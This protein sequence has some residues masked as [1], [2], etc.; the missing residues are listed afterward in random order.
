[1]S[2]KKALELDAKNDFSDDAKKFMRTCVENY[3]SK[4]YSMYYVKKYDEAVMYSEK[5]FELSQKY[6]GKTD[7]FSLNT[8]AYCAAKAKQFDKSITLY[9][10]LI[11]LNYKAIVGYAAIIELN[12]QKAD[13]PGL[14]AAITK[15]RTTFPNEYSFILEELNLAIREGKVDEAIKNLNLAIEKDPKNA[16]LHLVLGQTYQKMAFGDTKPANFDELLKRSESEFKLATDIKVD[17]FTGFYNFGVFY[18]NWG[19]NILNGSQKLTKMVEIQAEEKKANDLFLKA[20]PLLEKA[21][22]INKTDKDTMRALK[23]LYAKTGQAD[24]DKYRKLNDLLKN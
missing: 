16:E 18:S 8:A 13:D 15:A 6:L 24:T 17:Y 3:A 11:A 2:Y 14:K 9:E 5:A 23:Q 22:E 21:M 12:K 4:A 10:R 19:A 7:T 20:I 1:M